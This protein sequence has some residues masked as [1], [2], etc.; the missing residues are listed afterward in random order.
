MHESQPSVERLWRTTLEH[1]PVGMTIVSPT[2]E[3]LTAN[4]A[5]CA[6][7]GYSED[8]LRVLTFPQITHPADLE[9]DLDLFE[10]TLAGKRSSYRMLKRYLHADG[11]VVWG[12]L[13]VALLRGEDGAPLHF[14]SQIVDV[15][16][17][18]A[19]RERLTQAMGVI[20]RQ[21]RKAQAILD[22]VDVGLVLLDQNGHY[23]QM[24][25]RHRDF[26]EQAYPAGH[27]GQA[28]QLGEVFADDAATLLSYDQMPTV[29]A[30]RGEEFDDY[31]IWVGADPGTR[32]ALSVSARLVRDPD[33]APAGAALAYKDITDLMR[34]LRAQEDFVADVSHELRSPLTS[35]LGHLELL[36]ES[37]RLPPELRHQVEV[38]QRNTDRLRDLVSDL[39]ET[40]ALRD[41]P[42]LLAP[43]PTDVALVAREV[44]ES[45]QPTAD[46]AGV[47]L[48]VDAPG[49]V[50]AVVDDRRIR[51][52]LDNLVSNAVKYTDTGGRV[53]VRLRIVDGVVELT[54]ADDGIGIMD[55]ELDQLFIPFFRTEAARRRV[56]PGVGLGL[57]IVRAIVEAHGGQVDVAS[58]PGEGSSFVVTL[59]RGSAS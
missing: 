40:A 2:G 44:V 16:V 52:V 10:Q 29:R 59:P 46:A 58:T 42:P 32:R 53:D 17:Q 4:R 35:V 48:T 27:A 14:I 28:G 39:L 41:G 20:D 30:V 24:N 56:S 7:L 22:T 13:S 37:E 55:E 25:L 12:D 6:M 15:T 50:S 54:V 18:Q 34:A 21:S 9:A 11:S 43:S 57:G 47:A 23:E 51:Q 31:R 3:L 1:S 33:G 38:M 49:E 36:L 45:A 19:D 5:L 26:I 8:E